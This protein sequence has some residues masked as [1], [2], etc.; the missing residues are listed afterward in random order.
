MFIAQ[1]IS[2][3]LP[4]KLPYTYIFSRDVNFKDVTNPVILFLRITNP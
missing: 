4:Y 2:T 1:L 3:D